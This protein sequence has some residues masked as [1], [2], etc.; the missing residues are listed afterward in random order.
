MVYSHLISAAMIKMVMGCD[1]SDDFDA[2]F[3]CSSFDLWHVVRIYGC[4]FLCVLVDEEIGVI[5]LTHGD[6]DDLHF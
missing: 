2:C 6:W 4:C 5:V 3:F 1:G